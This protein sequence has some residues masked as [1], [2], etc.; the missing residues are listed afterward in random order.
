MKIKYSTHYP[1]CHRVHRDCYSEWC[2]RMQDA[3]WTAINHADDPAS[4][5]LALFSANPE[6]WEYTSKRG[7]I[8][9]CH[10]EVEDYWARG[11]LP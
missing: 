10:E 11:E 8:T 3:G 7:T 4:L 1:Y 6:Y 2:R 9:L 5:L